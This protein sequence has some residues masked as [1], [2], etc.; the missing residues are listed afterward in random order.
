MAEQVSVVCDVLATIEARN[1]DRLARL[2]HPEVHWTTPAAE[3]ELQ[4]PDAVLRCLS[5]SAWELDQAAS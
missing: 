4:G 5:D 1:W 2:L 3:D